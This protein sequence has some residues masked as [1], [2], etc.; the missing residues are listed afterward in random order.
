MITFADFHALSV[1]VA[2]LLTGR[3]V[4]IRWRPPNSIGAIGAASK[5]FDKFVIEVDPALEQ[6]QSLSVYLHEVA[7]IALHGGEMRNSAAAV[8][9]SASRVDNCV[10]DRG[11]LTRELEADQLAAFWL[12]QAE[13]ATYMLTPYR[14]LEALKKLYSQ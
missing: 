9:P 3:A 6:D 2:E 14:L 13:Q 11:Y 12:D 8:R 7:H 5:F 10:I 4:V 1:E